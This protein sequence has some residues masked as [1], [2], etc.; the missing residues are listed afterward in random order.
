MK[1]RISSRT[2]FPL[3]ENHLKHYELLLHRKY[4]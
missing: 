3:V 2:P 4:R 1:K